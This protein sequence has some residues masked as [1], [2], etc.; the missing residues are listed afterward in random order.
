M[1]GKFTI[2]CTAW[3]SVKKNTLLGFATVRIAELRFTLVDCPVNMSH[4]KI[5]ASPPSKP[6]IKD[7]EVVIGDN[8]KPQYDPVMAFDGREVRDAFSQRV[9]EAVTRFDPNALALEGAT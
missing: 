9:V 3:R 8:G 1:S 2:T 6:R 4:G 7:G 5:W